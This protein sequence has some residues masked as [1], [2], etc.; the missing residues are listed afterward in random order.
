[1]ACDRLNELRQ[2]V[3]I[4]S[5]CPLPDVLLRLNSLRKTV[6]GFVSLQQQEEAVARV[7]S[8]SEGRIKT[9]QKVIDKHRPVCE[10]LR[11]AIAVLEGIQREHSAEKYFRKFFTNNLQQ[12]SNLFSVMHAP[13]DFEKIVWQE[14]NPTA[15]RAV[16]RI[17]SAGCPVSTLS[18][19]QRNA[20]SLA[21]FLT[22]NQKVS[23]GPSVIMLDDPVIHV[24][25]L[26]IVS[27]FDCLRELLS[28]FQRQIFFTTASAKTANL[29]KKKFDY[30]GTDSFR[31]FELDVQ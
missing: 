1:M 16:R 3:D 13:R 14:E 19:G 6:E 15:I 26:N 9:A 7:M 12:I 10:R 30:L 20:L 21:I 18:S 11:K 8:E 31:E 29:F 23:R 2:I 24:D 17:D 28:G 4:E 5:S 27:F 25:D 22:M